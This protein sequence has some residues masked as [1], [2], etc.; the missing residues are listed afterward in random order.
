MEAEP[1]SELLS[2]F[3]KLD[4]GQRPK[5]ENY[6]IYLQTCSVLS[7]GFLSPWKWDW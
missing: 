7:F 2:F 6:V 5:K 3:K 1:A 4:N